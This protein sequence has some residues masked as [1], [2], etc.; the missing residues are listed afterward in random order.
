[1]SGAK[2]AQFI[3]CE[4]RWWEGMLW[5]RQRWEQQLVYTSLL[6]WLLFAKTGLLTFQGWEAQAVCGQLGRQEW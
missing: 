1:M 2:L 5:K 3:D 6:L 4:Q